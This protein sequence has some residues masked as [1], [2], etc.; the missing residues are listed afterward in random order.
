MRYLL[1]C[2][3]LL[4]L[5]PLR[6]QDND[7]D[8]AIISAI[9]TYNTQPGRRY[10]YQEVDRLLQPSD[11]VGV[12]YLQLVDRATGEPVEGLIDLMIVSG[13]Q[14]WLPAQMGYQA[15]YDALPPRLTAR[16]DTAPFVPQP[17]PALAPTTP[18]GLPYPHGSFGTVTRSHSVHGTGKIDF[19]LTGRDIAA[20]KDGT[21]IYAD[22]TR[23]TTGFW[24]YWNLVV[25]QHSPHEYTLY[26]HLAP[27]S[28][29]AAIRDG[30]DADFRCDVPVERG[31]IIGREG[32]TGRSTD[33]HLHVAF[34]QQVGF[35][36]YPDFADDDGDGDRLE[37]VPTAFLYALQNASFAGYTPAAVAD[38]PYGRLEQ[39][40]HTA[41]LPP[42][43]DVVQNGDFSAGTDAWT[44]LGQ[45]NWQ[46]ADGL[47][48]A[49]RL[50]A[51]DPPFAAFYQD[52]GHSANPDHALSLSL[53]LGNDSNIDKTATVELLNADGRQYGALTC[54]FVVLANT[55]LADYQLQGTPGSTWAAVRLQ[56]SLS[57]ADGAPAL[58]VD[59]ITLRRLQTDLAETTCHT[60]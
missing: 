36:S 41:P 1:L 5:A 55:P 14:T 12:V 54:R 21:I 17:D 32:N 49:T 26:G 44:P 34:G 37:P 40:A 51:A 22:D 53:R 28:L 56:I 39:A 42:D 11:S 48:R 24:W 13:T 38:W 2:L 16:I 7:V 23:R 57:P 15:A 20:A 4:P 43:T 35:V 33:P 25:I 59:D 27:D 9:A 52:V 6:A 60:P 8:T 30:C 18:Y 3:C 46:T 47:L 45:L 29:P 31:E 19:D 58:L 50:R 10:H